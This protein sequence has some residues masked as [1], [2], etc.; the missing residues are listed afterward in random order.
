MSGLTYFGDE[1]AKR[2]EQWQRGGRTLT[3]AKKLPDGGSGA[4]LALVYH[5]GDADHP[6]HQL[7]LKLCA[8]DEGSVNEPEDLEAAWQS[9]PAFNQGAR[10][11]DFPQRRLVRQVYPPLAV[12]DTWLMFL[13]VALDDRGHHPLTS[14]SAVTSLADKAQVAAAVIRSVLTEWNPDPRPDHGMSAQ[15][16][17]F[18]ALGHRAA[19][20][21]HLAHTTARILGQEAQRSTLTLPGWSEAL[22]NPTPFCDRLPLAGLK[23]PTVARGRAHYDLHPGNIMVATHPS[24]DPDSHRLVDLSRFQQQGLLLRDPVHLTLCLV[25][26]YLPEL[27]ERALNELAELLLAQDDQVTMPQHSL[28]PAGL[29]ST[30]QLLRSAPD[31]WRS[32]RDYD[33][34]AWHP[35]YLLA[36]QACALMFITRRAKRKEQLWFLQLAARACAAFRDIALPVAS[37]PSATLHEAPATPAS[38]ASNDDVLSAPLQAEL[39]RQRQYLEH[40]RTRCADPRFDGVLT[41]NLRVVVNRCERLNRLAQ[42]GPQE[43]GNPIFQ[44]QCMTV[45]Q[46]AAVLETVRNRPSEATEYEAARGDFIAA[47]TDLLEHPGIDAESAVEHQTATGRVGRTK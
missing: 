38:P 33:L 4:R 39:V 3:L 2:L 31:S 18:H 1:A 30:I 27:G 25:C 21:S 47:L 36:L 10:S 26:D 29:L 35:Q 19:S 11:F 6:Q 5:E 44:R 28:L 43:G 45:L 23:P 8:P 41:E 40:A 34:T 37:H 32:I 12:G 22:P 14:L 9:G 42:D 7:L 17:L 46:T 15:D 16:F 24:L 20:D 13:R